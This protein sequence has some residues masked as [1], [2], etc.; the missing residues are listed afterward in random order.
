MKLK[1]K[2]VLAALLSACAVAVAFISLQAVDLLHAEPRKKWKDAAIVEINR[3]SNDPTWLGAELTSI[4]QNLAAEKEPEGNW[5]SPSLLLMKNGDWIAYTAKCSKEDW[6]IHD[7]FI[8][9]ASDGRWY[10]STF[11][12]CVRMLDLRMEQQPQDLGKFTKTFSL[13]EFDGRSD[14]CLKKTWPPPKP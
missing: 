8:G 4:K 2:L 14:E 9:R 5:F 10:Y 7:I 11:H 1:T 6:R 12:F 13:R 3:K